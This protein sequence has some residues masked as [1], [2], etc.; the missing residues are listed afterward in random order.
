MVEHR[1]RRDDIHVMKD[2][3]LGRG[4]AYPIFVRDLPDIFG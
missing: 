2:E 1:G 4:G 3:D